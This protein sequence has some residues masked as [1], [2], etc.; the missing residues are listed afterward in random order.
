MQELMQKVPPSDSDA[1]TY[2]VIKVT[3]SVSDPAKF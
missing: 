1:L 2:E 3:P